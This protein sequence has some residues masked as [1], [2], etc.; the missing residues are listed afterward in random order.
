MASFSLFLYHS[1]LL[2][3]KW[4]R[5]YHHQDRII[6]LIICGA[7]KIEARSIFNHHYL[8]CNRFSALSCLFY[9]RVNN[10]RHKPW[11]LKIPPSHYKH[12]TTVIFIQMTKILL[13][14]F[15]CIEVILREG[16]SASKLCC[17]GIHKF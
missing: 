3:E 17:P 15:N 16:I 7:S 5:F 4:S 6:L 9:K 14:R 8:F 2:V 10:Q 1:D 12:T 13:K 11:K